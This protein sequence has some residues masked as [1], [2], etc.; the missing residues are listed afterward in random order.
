MSEVPSPQPR[1]VVGLG[2]PGREY[3]FTPH[4]LGFL[5]VDRLAQ[6]TKA[7]VERP[8]ARSLTAHT[9]IEAQPVVLAKPQTYMNLSGLAVRELLKKFG[10]GPESL[11]VVYDEL[12]L[13]AGTIRIRERGSA[14]GHHGLESILGAL[15]TDEFLRVRLGIGPDHPVEDAAAYVLRPYSRSDQKQVQEL[16]DRAAQAVRTIFRDG[17]ARAMTEFNRRPE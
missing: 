2:N 10:A 3:G 5:V 9:E 1:I 14:G 16:V 13:P 7:R 4:N 17:P 15:G 12:D 11:L 6:D 8:E